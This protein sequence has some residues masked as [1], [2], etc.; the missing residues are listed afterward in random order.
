MPTHGVLALALVECL[1]GS[2]ENDQ[3]L[4]DAVKSEAAG[5]SYT[6]NGP[7]HGPH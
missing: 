7:Y 2:K 4:D 1:T 3:A 6:P 5:S